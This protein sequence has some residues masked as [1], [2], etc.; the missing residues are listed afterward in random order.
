MMGY[1]IASFIIL[2]SQIWFFKRKIVTLKNENNTTD[3]D[4]VHELMKRMLYLWF[5]VYFLGNFYMGA[6]GFRSLGYSIF[7]G[8]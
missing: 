1:C 5:A 4:E 7:C 2:S 3:D 8:A 6:N